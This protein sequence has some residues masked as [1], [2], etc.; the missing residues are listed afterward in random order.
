VL[1]FGS[2]GAACSSSASR[3]DLGT[4]ATSGMAAGGN[5]R[6]GT[7][8]RELGAGT[9]LTGDPDFKTAPYVRTRCEDPDGILFEYI[10]HQYSNDSAFLGVAIVGHCYPG[11]VDLMVTPPAQTVVPPDQLMAFGCKDRC[12]FNWGA[13]VMRFFM[14]HPKK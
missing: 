8:R 2:I 12:D 1:A 5:G 14:A 9:V 6:G 3:K 10:Q 7:G 4:A 11:S 13:E